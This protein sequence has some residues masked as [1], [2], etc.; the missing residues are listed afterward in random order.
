MLYS[1]DAILQGKEVS[2][3]GVSPTAPY[4]VVS[5]VHGSVGDVG[6]GKYVGAV[7]VTVQ[8]CGPDLAQTMLLHD[9]D[10]R[11]TRSVVVVGGSDGHNGV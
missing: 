4:D 6:R 2:V 5:Q 9:S 10:L 1:N 11:Q 3:L 7:V 8:W